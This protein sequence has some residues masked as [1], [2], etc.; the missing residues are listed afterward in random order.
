MQ[1]PA[2]NKAEFVAYYLL[3]MAATF[4]NFKKK[5]DELQKVLRSA[6]PE[7]QVG[8]RARACICGRV[9]V[10]VCVCVCV[11]A[12]ACV[13]VFASASVVYACV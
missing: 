10:C 11:R 6:G 13:C 1:L 5:P 12:R 4:G 8:A 7:V 3:Y 9:C 2:P